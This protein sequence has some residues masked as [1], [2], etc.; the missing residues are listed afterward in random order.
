M[1]CDDVVIE[2]NIITGNDSVGVTFT[3]F[4]LAGNAAND[5]DSDPNP[6][7]PKILNN[8][9]QNN[10]N[11]PA[12]VVRAALAAVLTTTGPD[13][14][15]TVGMNDGC[16][17]NPERYRTIGLDKYAECEFS[18][19]A[20]VASYT[21]PEPVPAR[22]MEDMDKGKLAFYGVCWL[23]CLWLKDDWPADANHSGFVHG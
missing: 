9:M 10:G 23:S 16:I 5:P 13:I 22:S 14:V 21:L 1:A 15:D 2:G 6:N 20:N 19:T 4:T 12:P 17:L 11:N 8:I 3:D 7:R 18:T